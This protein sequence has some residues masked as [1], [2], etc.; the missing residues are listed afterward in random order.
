MGS[1]HQHDMAVDRQSM[2]HPVQGVPSPSHTRTITRYEWVSFMGFL[3]YTAVM[4]Q[5]AWIRHHQLVFKGNWLFLIWDKDQLVPCP[6]YLRSLLRSWFELD[7]LATQLPQTQSLPTIL[8]STC[9]MGFQVCPHPQP[10]FIMGFMY[11]AVFV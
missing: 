6:P 2:S 7:I 10:D 1:L 9:Q 11:Q 3:D 5:L 8:S 4:V